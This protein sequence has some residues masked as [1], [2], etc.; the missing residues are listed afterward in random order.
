MP[1]F[2]SN[3][4]STILYGSIFSELLRLI[5]CTI[6]INDFIPKASDLFSRMITQG[7]SRTTL[8]K[9]LK[10]GFSSLLN[11]FSKVW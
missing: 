2:S 9:Q 4:P 6:R 10:K 1:H 3:I 11:C 7:G 5:S 8:I